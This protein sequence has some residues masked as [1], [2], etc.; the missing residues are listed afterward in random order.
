MS[1]YLVSMFAGERVAVTT[2]A[3]V[4]IHNEEGV[5][6]SN[7]SVEGVFLDSDI[8]FVYLGSREGVETAINKRSIISIDLVSSE[9]EMMLDP[10]RPKKEEMS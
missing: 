10:N 7:V 3:K 2:T 1:E 6:E 4:I 9:A 5:M 8:D